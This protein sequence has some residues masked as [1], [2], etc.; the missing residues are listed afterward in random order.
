[1]I[2]T[3]LLI[4][5]NSWII[6]PAGWLWS[7]SVNR[8]L[9]G[10]SEPTGLQSNWRRKQQQTSTLVKPPKL[11]EGHLVNY[12]KNR[13]RIG[14]LRK[15]TKK[16]GKTKKAKFWGL[17]PPTHLPPT[18]SSSP[19]PRPPATLRNLCGSGEPLG[20]VTRAVYV[21]TRNEQTNRNRGLESLE[22]SS[23][24]SS[25]L[26][27]QGLNMLEL[28]RALVCSTKSLFLKLANVCQWISNA[29]L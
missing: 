18:P 16:K 21:A 3:S 8:T 24:Y 17:L 12:Y 1:M 29:Y 26:S 14:N 27:L 10:L 9:K 25:R 4:P 28:L 19:C 23:R 13:K 11:P 5:Q 20:S 2:F 15:S 22:T 6:C 7:P